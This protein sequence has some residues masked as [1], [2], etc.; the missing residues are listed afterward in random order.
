LRDTELL[1]AK[2]DDIVG[3]EGFGAHLASIASAK[4]IPGQ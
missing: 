4:Q 1:E 3:A 2:L